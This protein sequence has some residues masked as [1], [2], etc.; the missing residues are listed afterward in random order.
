MLQIKQNRKIPIIWEKQQAPTG[1]WSVICLLQGTNQKI[2]FS[3]ACRTLFLFRIQS[4]AK[5]RVFSLFSALLIARVFPRR[6]TNTN[7][8]SPSPPPRTLWISE[9]RMASNNGTILHLC[10]QFFRERQVHSERHTGSIAFLDWV[11]FH[12]KGLFYSFFYL[13][14]ARCL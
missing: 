9:K 8:P 2:H 7:T 10:P 6:L 5:K 3:F 12:E 14:F 11:T 13:F 4:H 1:E